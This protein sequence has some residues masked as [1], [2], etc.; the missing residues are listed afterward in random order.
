MAAS[1]VRHVA[2]TWRQRVSLSPASLFAPVQRF[3]S[4]SLLRQR[5]S[6]LEQESTEEAVKWHSET[7]SPFSLF[8]PVQRFSSLSLLRQRASKLEQESTEEAV[9]WHS[10]TVSPFSLFAPVQRFSSPFASPAT[11]KQVGTGVNGGSRE[12]AQRAFLCFFLFNDS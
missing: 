11:S 1:Q 10:E 8:A 7:V 4:L 9:K 3:S 2:F 6:K 12:V 5:A